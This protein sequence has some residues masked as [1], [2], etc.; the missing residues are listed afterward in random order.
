M[1]KDSNKQQDIVNFEKEL[2]E[3]KKKHN[4]DPVATIE[5]PQY[6]ELPEEVLLALKVL[7]KH[8]YKIML[9]Y[10]IIQ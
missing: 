8:R 10:R 5:F 7:E 4:L 2:Q 1:S 3:L 9:T 6:R